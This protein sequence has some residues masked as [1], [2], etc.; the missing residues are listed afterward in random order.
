MDYAGIVS[1]V[2]EAVTEFSPGDAVYGLNHQAS[3]TAAEYLLLT[4]RKQH[5]IEKLPG[6]FSFEEAGSFA[7]SGYTA[8]TALLRADNEIPGGLKRKTV[9]VTG[10]FLRP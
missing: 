7:A 9:L 1:A 5:S 2:G 4:P 8:V 10:R 6:S 3:S